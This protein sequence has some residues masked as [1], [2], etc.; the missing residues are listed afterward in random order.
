MSDFVLEIGFENVP[1]SY[2]PPAI[3]QLSADAHAMLARCRL[4]HGEIYT[5]ATP[6]RLVLTVAGLADRQSQS[7]ELVTGPP[8]A[9]AFNPDGTP[10]PAAEG[11]ARGH[12]VA[13]AALERVAT[14]KGEYLG[15]RKRL[16]CARTSEVLPLEL[17]ALV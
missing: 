10:T 9:R 8:V 13:V 5:T 11:F 1:A 4:A 6:R 14:P 17:P 2:L 15:M 7:E 3:E 16:P 12:G